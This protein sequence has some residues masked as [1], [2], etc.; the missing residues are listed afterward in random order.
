MKFLK[1]YDGTDSIN[2][3]FIK[4]IYIDDDNPKRVCLI[5][6]FDYVGDYDVYEAPDIAK[7]F[8]GEFIL[9]IFNSDDEEYN[10]TAAKKYFTELIDK[11]NDGDFYE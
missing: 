9:K 1:D 11:L 7:F 5:A 10:L 8:Y 2:I 3:K 4:R 6:T